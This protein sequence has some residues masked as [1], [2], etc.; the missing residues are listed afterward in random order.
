MISQNL[1]GSGR[2]VQSGHCEPIGNI[3]VP[4][5]APWYGTPELHEGTSS[6]LLGRTGENLKP[7]PL[8][9]NGISPGFC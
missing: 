2:N 8:G 1:E 6:A 4:Y 7:E 5:L 9:T 3:G